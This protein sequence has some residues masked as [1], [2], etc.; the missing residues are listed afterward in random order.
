MILKSKNTNFTNTKAHGKFNR[1]AVFNKFSFGK[2]VSK[3][4]THLRQK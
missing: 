2:K 1:I 3:Y 4:L